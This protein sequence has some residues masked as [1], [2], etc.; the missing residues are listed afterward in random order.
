MS[1]RRLH[2]QPR[3]PG[4]I[5]RA[6]AGRREQA[7]LTTK[8]GL[9]RDDRGGFAGFNGRPEY[10]RAAC[11]ASLRRLRT[12]WIDL[13][14]QHRIDPPVPVEETVGAMAEGK[15]RHLDLS[16]A[17]P[18]ELR[19]AHTIRPIAALQTEYSLW[20]RDPE[21]ELLPT[22]RKLGIGF[23]AYAP[24]GRGCLAG[25][26]SGPADLGQDDLRRQSPRF[27]EK[28]LRINERIAAAVRRMA[29]RLGATPAQVALAWL[30]AKGPDIVP[31]P[32]PNG[33]DI[34]R[35]TAGP[36]SSS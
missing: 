13:Y 5:G 2:R 27:H 4:L 6:M 8:F 11:D 33:A 1:A 21:S 12:D 29:D 20:S 7:V 24:L 32:A 10:V 3:P 36:R 15:V 17:S 19:R 26:V 31:V 34:S 22:V 23:V 18:D 16:E 35:T 25:S 9:V 28:N 30:L 14:Y